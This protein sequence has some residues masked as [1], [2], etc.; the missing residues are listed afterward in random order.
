M[1]TFAASAAGYRNLW[2][3]AKLQAGKKAEADKV[4]RRIIANRARYEAVGA[5]FGKPFLWPLIGALHDREAG[6]SFAGVLHNGE[7]IIGTG[8][9]TS[10]V[11]AGRGPFSTWENAAVDALT[12]PGKRWDQIKDW[13]IERWLYQ[14]EAFN[15]FGYTSR[16]VNSP[17][18]WSGTSKQQRGKYVADHVWG[19]SAWDMQLGV[20]AVLEAIFAIDPSLAPSRPTVPAPVVVGGAATIPVIVG[21]AATGDPAY[22]VGA[23]IAVSAIIIAY[24]GVQYMPKFLTNWRTSLAGVAAVLAAGIH[25]VYPQVPDLSPIAALLIGLLA[26]DSNV[27]GGS[28]KQ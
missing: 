4:A 14:A 21:S 19:P 11:P 18:V 16:G 27:T 13:P 25:Q 12:M 6:G 3:A 22:A 1:P 5:R 8:R 20:A 10:L 9:R 23:L 26:K 2:G 24:L 17:Y 7:H 28:V 15:G